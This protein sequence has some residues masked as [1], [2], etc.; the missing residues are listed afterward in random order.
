MGEET[1]VWFF[2]IRRTVHAAESK[3]RADHANY[4]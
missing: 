4:A 2:S 1:E 3:W